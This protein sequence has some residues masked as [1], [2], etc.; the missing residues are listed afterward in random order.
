MRKPRI[1]TWL[2]GA[3]DEF[4]DAVGAPA[5][6]VAGAVQPLAAAERIGDETLGVELGPAQVAARQPAAADVQLAD[7]ARPATGACGR[8]RARSTCVS[9]IGRP[10]GIDDGVGR[11]VA[12][13]RV[14]RRERRAL[15]RAVAVDELGVRQRRERAPHVRRRQRLAAGEQ[16]RAGRAGARV[17]VDDRVEQRRGQPRAWS[18]RAR[19][20]P[21]ASAAAGRAPAR[22]GSRTRPPLSSGPHSSSVEAS[23]PSG[24][25]CRKQVVVVEP[26]VVDVADQPHDR[27]VLDLHALGRAGRARGV[28]H[29]GEP[30]GRGRALER[31]LGRIERRRD[32]IDHE[33]VRDDP[34]RAA[35]ARRR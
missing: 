16:L 25:A 15:G 5:H 9:A 30:V 14:G 33:G 26:D 27:A 31:T 21:R 4:E 18:R 35:R 23:N 22:G 24:A 29:V 1:L 12:R 28:H 7:L 13:D 10:I 17:V 32:R 19:R 3:A 2:I 34:C 20:S 6:Q 8:R 11:Q